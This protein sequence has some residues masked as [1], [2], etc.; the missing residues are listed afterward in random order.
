MLVL[1]RTFAAPLERFRSYRDS[2]H[3]GDSARPGAAA[4]GARAADEARYGAAAVARVV[5][6]NRV[7]AALYAHA[8][9][10][11]DARWASMLAQLAPADRAL[12]F[13][14]ED[15]GGRRRASGGQVTYTLKAP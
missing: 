6:R 8:A 1:K 7:D 14:A 3:P 2:P 15:G 10:L 9:E 12:R 11:F 4:G 5:S 13:V